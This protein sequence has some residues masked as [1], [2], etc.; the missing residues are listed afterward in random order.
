MYSCAHY[1]YNSN[2]LYYPQVLGYLIQRRES[3][4]ATVSYSGVPTSVLNKRD[5]FEESSDDR[6]SEESAHDKER[7]QLAAPM[8][9]WRRVRRA[10]GASRD[11]L[12][13]GA[14]ERILVGFW[15]QNAGVLSTGQLELMLPLRA[16]DT[17]AVALRRHSLS[18]LRGDALTSFS[19]H[20]LARFDSDQPALEGTTATRGTPPP[21]SFPITSDPPGELRESQQQEELPSEPQGGNGSD[22]AHTRGDNDVESEPY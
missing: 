8:G 18:A 13:T 6:P 20:L 2:L 5:A 4:A 12:A 19:G 9:V 22:D 7:E 3:S 14:F 11:D 15:G 16:G 10:S 1:I 17:L 21:F